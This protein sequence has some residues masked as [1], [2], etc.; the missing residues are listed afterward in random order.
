MM[1]GLIVQ[2]LRRSYS[3]SRRQ[4]SY[5]KEAAMRPEDIMHQH[6]DDDSELDEF[7]V[8]NETTMLKGRVIRAG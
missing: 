5:A 2:A 8:L 3:H 7:C 1:H 6:N 4:R